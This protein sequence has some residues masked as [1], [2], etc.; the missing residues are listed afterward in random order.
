MFDSSG[1][2]VANMWMPTVATD[3]LQSPLGTPHEALDVGQQLSRVSRMGSL[4]S[5]GLD[6]VVEILVRFEFG[7]VP[8]QE[9]QANLSPVSHH[10]RCHVPCFMDGMRADDHED[11]LL[12]MTD[13]PVQK[14][15]TH[16]RREA[17]LEHHEDRLSS[18]GDLQEH[19]APKAL[20]RAGA[21]W[22]LATSAPGAASL[23][24][25]THL[26][27]V[28]PKDRCAL[29]LR[30]DPD[31]GILLLEPPAHGCRVLLIGSAQGFLG[32]EPP[33]PQTR[34]TVQTE[35]RTP[36]RRAIMSWTASWVHN[37]NGNLSWSGY[38]SVISRTVIAAW[39]SFSS[40]MRGRPRGR[41]RTACKP[42]SRRRRSQAL[43]EVTGDFKDSGCFGLRHPC[44][45][46]PNNPQAERLL[47]RRGDQAH[48]SALHGRIDTEKN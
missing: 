7:A 43:T 47:G 3:L 17:A 36:N 12:G 22:R 39:Y 37:T 29:P 27:F 42:P 23:V 24:V 46:N 9:K 14:R 11:F 34:P 18:V 19:V 32:S 5:I 13:Q 48:V 40:K 45:H 1:C 31:G 20:A 33:P 10:P 15:C 35:R 6:V 44:L 21:H 4:H 26:R 2:C 41:D 38:R 16:R 25:R 8:G 30:Q 28:A